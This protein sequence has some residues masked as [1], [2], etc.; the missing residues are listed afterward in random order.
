MFSNIPN[1]WLNGKC[2]KFTLLYR[3][4]IGRPRQP[5]VCIFKVKIAALGPLKRVFPGL[6]KLI[7]NFIAASSNLVFD[8]P[9]QGNKNYTIHRACT[10]LYLYKIIGLLK[11]VNLMT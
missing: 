1:I 6:L 5:S 3:I 2:I 10:E 9:Q 8:F 7:S 4:I 11:D